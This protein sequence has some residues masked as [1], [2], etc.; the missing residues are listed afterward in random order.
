MNSHQWLDYYKQNRQN[1][2]EPKWN[3]PCALEPGL[4]R[5]LAKSLSHFQLGETGGGTYL[6]DQA[7][8]QVSDDP[9]YVDALHYFVAEEGEHARLLECLVLRFGG[10]TIRRHWTHE[11]FRL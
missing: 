3:S 7:C 8:K 1:R 5:V 10:A 4:Q 2:P 6:I 9:T 11:L